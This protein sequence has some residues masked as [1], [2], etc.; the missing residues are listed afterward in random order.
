MMQ[1]R[2]AEWGWL[3]LATLSLVLASA[4]YSSLPPLLTTHWNARGV[5]N[6]YMSR[7]WGIGLF[8]IMS[9]GLAMLFWAIPRIDPRRKNFPS[10][11][12]YYD[13]LAILLLL[14]LLAV[15]VFVVLWNLGRQYSPMPLV[16]IG[17]GCLVFYTGVLCA[18]A[19]PN[20]FVG[21][22]TPWTLSSEAVW[23]KTH[24]VGARLFKAAGILALA[25]AFF[26][27]SEASGAL[28]TGPRPVRGR[29]HAGLFLPGIP[30]GSRRR[31]TRQPTLFFLCLH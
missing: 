26:P 3:A 1:L 4:V 30:E 5:P 19:R 11:L 6:G 18:H 28:C 21:I 22:R 25:G 20:W 7:F 9:F 17:V 31:V 24:K 8:P 2:K 12:A 15:Q 23:Y 29:L 13:A 14:F 16:S 27:I 10:F